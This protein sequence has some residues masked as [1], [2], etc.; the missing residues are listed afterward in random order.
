MSAVDTD[1]PFIRF[2]FLLDS[3]RTAIGTGWSDDDF[4]ALVTRLDQAVAAIDGRGFLVTPFDRYPDLAAALGLVTDRLW[5]KDDTANVAGSHKGRHL[6]GVLLTLAV[7]P[8]PP[9]SGELVIASC[10]NAAMAAAVLARAVER[11][12]RVFVPRWADPA[13]VARIESLEAR[14]EI[15]DRRPGEPGDPTYLRLLEAVAAGATPFSCQG[16]VT[17][18]CLDGG[19]TIG[20]EI[21]EQ[22]ALAGVE[23]RV[24]LLAQV[25]GG[26]LAVSA[27]TGLSGGIGEQWL[28]ADARLHAVQTAAC[29]PLARAWDLWQTTEPEESPADSFM[30]PWA[31]VGAS[32]ATG[33]LDD[34]TYDWQAVVEPMA[35]TGGWPIVVSEDQV[36]EANRFGRANTGIAVDHTGTAGLAGLLDPATVATL[37]PDEHVV[38]LFTGGQ[39]G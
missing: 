11:P 35:A 38:V 10:G 19:R 14:I 26:A 13:V 32:A 9:A 28:P 12:L 39:R 36:L 21:A 27:W 7:D 37:S 20:W 1:N 6:F 8:E 3:Y 23:G 30:W 4:V 15:A 22:L 24:R 16:T 2:R 29:A 34:V 25:G 31:P 18:S 33:I 17:P 5:V